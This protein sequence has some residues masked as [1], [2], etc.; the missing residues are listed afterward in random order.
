IRPSRARLSASFEQAL[1]WDDV[2]WLR[3]VTTLPI[4]LK[5]IQT[6][7]DAALAVEH[8]VEAI[9]VSNHG[10][11]A[12]YNARG[13]AEILPEVVETVADRLEIYVDGGI[14]TGSDILKAL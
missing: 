2:A 13:T 11:F 1:G 14:R 4:I 9:V 12:L 10:G 8:G 3:Q 6:A 7:E 5:G